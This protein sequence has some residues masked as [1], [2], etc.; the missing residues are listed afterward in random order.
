[1][2]DGRRP[3]LGSESF[4]NVLTY[5]S[6]HHL[7]QP[8]AVCREIQRVLVR[9]GVHFGSE[10]NR[11]VFRGLFDAL[12]KVAP[13]WHEE[14]GEQPLISASMLRTWTEGL[15]VEITERTSVYLPPHLCNWMGESISRGLLHLTD[16]FGAAVRPLNR[17]GGLLVFEIQKI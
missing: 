14:A 13:L 8:G 15:P 9:G 10:N 7:P 1:M 2:A 12:M 16:G 4:D 3:P 6:L 5:G 17:H 11:S